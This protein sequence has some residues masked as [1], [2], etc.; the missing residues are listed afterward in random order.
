MNK[1]TIEMKYLTLS[2][3][4]LLVTQT[5]VQTNYAQHNKLLLEARRATNAKAYKKALDHYEK[6][7]E[8]NGANSIA[9]YA[10]AAMCAAEIDNPT[11]CTKWLTEAIIK[12][13][14]EQD[15]L[16]DFTD[17]PVYEECAVNVLKNYNVFKNKYYQNLENLDVYFKIHRLLNRDQYARNINYYYLGVSEEEK[18]IAFKKLMDPETKKDTALMSKYRAISFPKPDST[19]LSFQ[20]TAMNYVDSLNIVELMKITDKHGWQKEAWLLLWHQRGSYGEDNWVWNY[21]IPLIN[22]EIANGLVAPHFWAMFEDLTSIR[23]TGK[24]IYGF[25]PGKV[26][27]EQVNEKRMSIGLSPLT[28]DEIESRNNN[29]YGGSIY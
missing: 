22:V 11:S 14:A 18:E 8:I 20:H 16:N 17:H 7:F 23:K 5:F 13:N 28:A 10:R 4:F 15:F 2:L 3:F 1:K 25:H 27:P 26:N 19:H 29:P 9:E 12:E 6:A 24:S 21:F